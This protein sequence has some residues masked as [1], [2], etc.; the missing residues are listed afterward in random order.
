MQ[1]LLTLILSTTLFN[2]G[3][4]QSTT[5]IHCGT[6]L[7]MTSLNAKSEMTIIVTDDKISDV[8]K[9][10]LE[11]DGDVEIINLK[12]HTVMPGLMDMHVHI[13]HE[14]SPKRYEEKFRH[15]D[16]DIAFRAAKYA[17]K[18][19]MAGF[20]TVRDL[21]GSGVNVSLRNAI[22][23]G[24]VEGPRI[25]TAEKSLA[26]TGG[27]ADP[28]NGVRNDLKG[29]PGPKEGVI[30]SVE[31]A[32]KAVRQRYKNGADC[33]KIT[34]TGGVLSVAK[35]GSG[36]QFTIEEVEAVV[37]AAKDY[38]M[39]TA[40]HAHGVEGMRRAIEGGI[41]SI[42]HG[43]MM[44]DELME[45]MKKHGTYYVPTI[46]AGKFV[47]EKAAIPGFYPAVIVPKA[48]AIGPMIQ[49]TFARAYK[50]GVKIAYG[51]DT[52]VSYHGDNGKEFFYMEEAGM[53][54]IK[55]IHSATVA[56]ADLLNISDEVGTIEKGK[57]ADI[58]AVKGDPLKEIKLMERVDFVMKGGEVYKR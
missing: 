4:A 47:A 31:D 15:N 18:T 51:T 44:N 22:N 38:G 1:K 48:L 33:I 41:T 40:A 30:N 21:G 46:S 54:A 53:P 50:K 37:K 10:Y 45:L 34:A 8:Q 49:E 58:V 36:P 19:L 56:A 17:E 26:T 20:T 27:H 6:L 9:G 24:Y 57:Y 11:A 42:E 32:Y 2:F 52:G 23:L 14:S 25:Y 12:S 7:D 39:T 43:T 13:E 5:Y 28:T 35:D 29:N 55:T 3:A 16:A